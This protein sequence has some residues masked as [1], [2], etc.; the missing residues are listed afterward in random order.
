MKDI[1]KAIKSLV[2]SIISAIL[3]KYDK[4]E[5]TFWDDYNFL[6]CDF[7]KR[8]T[9]KKTLPTTKINLPFVLQY[10]A[11]N[12]LYEYLHKHKSFSCMIWKLIIRN[13]QE[14]GFKI[15]Y[16]IQIDVR[17]GYVYLP[18]ECKWNLKNYSIIS[19]MG[20]NLELFKL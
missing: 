4:W 19:Q 18:Y 1:V 20:T 13:N 11:R 14:A 6:K 17:E 9:E 3:M 12:F 5:L 8:L 7:W 2:V 15:F 10:Y 16:N